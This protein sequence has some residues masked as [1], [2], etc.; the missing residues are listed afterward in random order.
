MKNIYL[1]KVGRNLNRTIRLAYSFGY[2]NLNLID[3][4]KSFLKGN[5]FS[6]KDVKLID[7][8]LPN[9]D[10]TLVLEY[11]ASKTITDINLDDFDNILIGGESVNL[12]SKLGVKVKIPTVNNFCL[13]TESALSIILHEINKKIF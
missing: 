7:S 8:I 1:Y 3:C 11:D 6:A 4:K 12:T 10:R 13:T 5:T 9:M 2:A